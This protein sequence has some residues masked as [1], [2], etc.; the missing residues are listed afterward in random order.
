MDARELVEKAMQATGCTS[1]RQL[2][3]MISVSHVAVGKWIRGENWPTFEQAAELAE[4]ANLPPAQTA[5][6]VRLSSPDAR[7]RYSKILQ[8][9]MRAAAAVATAYLL[10]R[11]DVQTMGE[12]MAFAPFAS[13]HYAKSRKMRGEA[14]YA[15]RTAASAFREF[16]DA[17][18][19]ESRVTGIAFGVCTLR[20]FRG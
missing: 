15:S 16:G 20:A 3:E 19:S 10:C 6:A 1:A 5:A 12:I 8:Q 14:K 4:L 13:I 2:A 9:M 11:L 7:A 17:P 18:L